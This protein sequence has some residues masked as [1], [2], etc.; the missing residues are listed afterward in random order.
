MTTTD[1]ATLDA[2]V[3]ELSAIGQLLELA[4]D[5]GKPVPSEAAGW[6]GGRLLELAGALLD[7]PRQREEAL[8]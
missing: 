1:S 8:S 4:D 3:K 7:A 2:A 6:I 5:A